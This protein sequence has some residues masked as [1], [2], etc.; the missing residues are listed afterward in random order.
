MNAGLT[1]TETAAT[2]NDLNPGDLLSSS[3]NVFAG[4]R[5]STQVAW[6]VAVRLFMIVIS[7]AVG[8]IAGRWLGSSGFGILAVVNLTVAYAVQIGN[9]G[10]VLA[11]TY[12]V[13][14]DARQLVPAGVNSLI[15]CLLWGSVVALLV[16]VLAAAVPGVF[17]DIPNRLM[18]VAVIAVPFQFITLFGLNLLL[19]MGLVERLNVLDALSQFLLL[20]NAV[21]ALVILGAGL[22]ALVSLN[23]A[24]SVFVSWVVV[25]VTV[26]AIKRR[27]EQAQSWAGDVS[28]FARMMRYAARM[29]LQT[30]AGL[31][32]FRSDLLIVKYFRGAAEVGVYAVASQVALLLMLVPAVIS[33]LLF[34]RVA[35]EKDPTGALACRITR[36]TVVVMLVICALAVPA[37]FA[38]PLF[39]GAQFSDATMQSLILLPGV[40]LVSIAGVLSNHFSAMGL[41]ITVPLFW[42]ITLVMNVAANLMVVPIYGARGA[43]FTS[44]ASYALVFVLISLYFRV[45]TGQSLRRVFIVNR[46]ELLAVI[47]LARPQELK[48]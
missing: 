14:R 40:F 1:E 43:A 2:G 17:G 19:A 27:K 3:P 32:L 18:S 4:R 9:L 36:H 39:Y 33:T 12:Y 42:I 37:L 47:R 22:W 48:P 6:T 10:L 45:R 20:V 24:A 26:V 28:L 46:P 11:N 30:V 41:P 21:V 31:L 35:A 5:F 7:L 8:I 13:A 38:L 23:S 29:H 25:L 44:A 16:V 34:P 15:F